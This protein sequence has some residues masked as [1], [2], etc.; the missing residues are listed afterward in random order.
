MEK[1]G[2]SDMAIRKPDFQNE[3]KDPKFL[4]KISILQKLLLFSLIILLGIGF[5]GY[6]VY[7]S[8]QK[9]LDSQQLIQH[10]E[11]VINLADKIRSFGI[12]IETATR[13]FVITK[14][15]T[16][17]EPLYNAQ[18]TVFADIEQLG[19]LTHDNPLQQ[20]RIDSLD[21]YMHRRL[22][23]SLQT[24]ALRS[25]QGFIAA[26][27]YTSTKEGKGY[28]GRLRQIT[29]SIQQ[30]ERALLE[31]RRQ[32]NEYSVTVFDRFLAV[33]FILMVVSAILFL[34]TI[35]KY[36]LQNKEKE[37]QAAELIIA[38][39]ELVFQNIEKEKRAEELIIANQEIK[40]SEEQFKAVNEELESFSYSVSHDLRAPVRAMNGYARMFEDKYGTQFDAEAIRLM[41]NIINNAKKMG[42]LIDDL[43]AFSQIGRKD[44]SKV[45]IKMYEMVANICKEVKDE[46]GDRN[47]EFD[48]GPLLPAQ[49]D[50][51]ALKQV[52]LNL[53]SN[54]IKYTRLKDKT[55]IEIGSEIKGTEI[56]YYIKD[57]GAGFDMRYVNK[58]FN[59]FQRLHSDE[60]FEGTGVGLAIVQRIIF[61]H[62]GRIWAEGKVNEGAIF[63][64][65]LNKS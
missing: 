52:W 18:K 49:A 38:N 12:D 24:I 19:Q 37:H 11:Q 44:M 64:F 14:D 48:I 30:E 6:T 61:K 42:M 56:V 59:I 45:N 1:P 32:T 28:T 23:F 27:T 15:S 2:E 7:K 43:L 10:T 34:I 4:M 65:T 54:A 51:T 53:I 55:V 9:L 22:D 8:N 31:Q 17:L 13:G 40:A 25:K 35:H 36:L 58:L 47:I 57:N 29:G 62:G 26:T 41:G 5:T 63:Y 46:Q 33:T 60:E 20:P 3:E 16:F 50:N 39:K 21:F